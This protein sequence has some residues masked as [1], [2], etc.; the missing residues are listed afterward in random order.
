M[1]IFSF[2]L[3]KNIKTNKEIKEEKKTEETLEYV[4]ISKNNSENHLG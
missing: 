4:E 1:A 3:Y 2:F